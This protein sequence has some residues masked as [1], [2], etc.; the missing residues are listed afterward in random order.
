MSDK[1]EHDGN[2]VCEAIIREIAR[3]SRWSAVMDA[4]KALLHVRQMQKSL[5]DEHKNPDA[6]TEGVVRS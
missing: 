1:F 4:W 6:M 2:L 3:A 5:S